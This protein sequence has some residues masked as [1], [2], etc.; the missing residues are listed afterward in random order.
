VTLTFANQT[1][2]RFKTEF[3]LKVKWGRILFKTYL[4]S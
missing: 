2:V 3:N 4:S 1:K